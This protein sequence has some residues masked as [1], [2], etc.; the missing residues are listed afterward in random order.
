MNHQDIKMTLRYV[1]LSPDSGRD[2]VVNLGF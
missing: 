1:K 2:A